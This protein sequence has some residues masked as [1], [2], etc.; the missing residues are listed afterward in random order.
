MDKGRGEIRSEIGKESGIV[1]EVPTMDSLGERYGAFGRWGMEAGK[2]AVFLVVTRLDVD[3]SVEAE[4]VNIYVNI[5][6]GDMG[7]KR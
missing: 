2:V 4:V 7:G 3:R 1:A 6:E 5:Q